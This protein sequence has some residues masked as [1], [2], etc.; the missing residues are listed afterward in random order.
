MSSARYTTGERV[1]CIPPNV[2][3]ARARGL[4][5]GCALPYSGAIAMAMPDA[6]SI[7]GATPPPSI[8]PSV[9]LRS[10]LDS[11]RDEG[12]RMSL[13]E[14]IAVIVPVCMDLQERHTRGERLYVHPSAIA[15]GPDGVA[16]VRPKLALVPTNA[17]DKFCLA[18]ELQRTL[19]PG[20]ACASVYSVGAILY[21]M[22][23]GH[24]VGPGM[25]RPREIEPSLPDALEVLIG[26]AIIGDRT[27]R[28]S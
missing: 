3:T 1:V 11:R 21:E 22:V 18:P 4:S 7:Q 8:P 5:C 17:S 15:P 12:R 19:E 2:W 24:H 20:D 26:K 23:T 27:H 16:R 25:H 6:S 14:A 10:L 9:T 13:E 28:P